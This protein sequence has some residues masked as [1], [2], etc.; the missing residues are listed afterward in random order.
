MKTIKGFDAVEMKRKGSLAVYERIKDMTLEE[1]LEYWR[2]QS[3]AL[4]REQKKA[5][6][7]QRSTKRA[8]SKMG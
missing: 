5:V 4:K 8:L 2:K 7:R 3:E 6:Q 1:E